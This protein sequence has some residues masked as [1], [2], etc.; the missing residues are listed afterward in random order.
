MGGCRKVA[1]PLSGPT[2]GRRMMK[3]FLAKKLRAVLVLSFSLAALLSVVAVATGAGGGSSPAQSE[4][5]ALKWVSTHERVLEHEALPCTGPRDPINFEIF[6]AGPSVSGV[7]LNT[8]VR[9][10]DASAP[11][12]EAP[13]NYTNYVYGHCQA[14]E[15]DSGCEPPLQIQ[16]FPACQRSLADYSYEGKP[17]PV[18]KLPNRGGAEVVEIDFFLDHRIEVYTKST[19][20][21]IFASSPSLAKKALALLRSQ[22][23]GE[24]PAIRPAALG[25]SPD[26]RL[27]APSEA[28][29]EGDL[30][31]RP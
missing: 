8:F 17:L 23:S 31:C 27:G 25:G 4:S 5:H 1:T 22:E 19:T 2:P 29:I 16:S 30:P 28:A 11:A 3:Q 21:V 15:G 20:I 13:A 26:E 12:D 14:V 24:P 9:R 6:S 7:P 18:R 10:C